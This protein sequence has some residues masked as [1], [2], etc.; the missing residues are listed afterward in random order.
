MHRIE[1]DDA[2][3]DAALGGCL[4]HA[5][6]DATRA[7]ELAQLSSRTQGRYQMPP[8]RPRDV[9]PEPWIFFLDDD[10]FDMRWFLEL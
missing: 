4:D 8:P 10:S 5:N 6:W 1:L 9:R 2:A 7:A 3:G